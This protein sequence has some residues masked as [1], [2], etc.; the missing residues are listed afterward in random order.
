MHGP[1]VQ[2]NL[3]CDGL[4]LKVF[5][6]PF[7]VSDSEGIAYSHLALEFAVVSSTKMCTQT[8]VGSEV[9]C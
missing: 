7:L 5:Q 3:V 1:G 2:A 6:D 9:T 8:V 4:R